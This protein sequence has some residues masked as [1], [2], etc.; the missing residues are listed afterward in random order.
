MNDNQRIMIVEYEIFN[1]QGLSIIL[2][3]SV[4]PIILSVDKANSGIEAL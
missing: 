1:I 2:Q 3:K 4:I